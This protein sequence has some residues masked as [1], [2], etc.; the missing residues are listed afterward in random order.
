MANTLT[1]LIPTL[2]QSA[3]TVARELVGFLNA[4]YRNSSAERAALNEPV[5]YPITP[6]A[7]TADITPGVTPPNDGDQAIG[8]GTIM[9]T[10]S[11]YSPIRWNGEETK[12]YQNNGTYGQTLADQFTQAMRALVNFM[13]SDVASLYVFASRSC[14]TAGTTP[15]GTAGDLSDVAN[16]DQ[17][18][19]DNGAPSSD[20]HLVLGSSAINKLKGKQSVLFKVNEAGTDALLRRGEIGD[21]EGFAIHNSAQVLTVAKGTGTSYVTSGS[22]APGVSSIALVTGSG[23][24]LAGDNV[25]FAADAN[26]TYVVGTGV[27][28]PGTIALNKPGA[29]V[30]IATANAMTIGNGGTRNMAFQRSAIHL[31]TRAPAMPQGGDM[32]DDMI[33][34]TDPL[35][36][37]TFQVCLYRGYKQ[38]RFEVGMAWGYAA[39]KPEFICNLLG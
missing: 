29:R 3:D 27:A 15:F 39:V 31:V 23:T 16:V 13:E 34:I 37:L 4:V 30:T 24:V 35:S 21:L 9:I 26:N 17:I 20:R 12:G 11:K 1:G 8:N 19:N 10:R 36:G 7:T 18:L 38:L 28:A 32:A 5:T 33:E 2:Y 6:P 22:T 14:G 25:T